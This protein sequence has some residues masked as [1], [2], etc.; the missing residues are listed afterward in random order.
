MLSLNIRSIARF[1][2]SRSAAPMLGLAACTS[3]SGCMDHTQIADL[4]ESAQIAREQ[5]ALEADRLTSLAADPSQPDAVRH[6]GATAAADLQAHLTALDTGLA[7][8]DQWLQNG[9][10]P[11]GMMQTIANKALPFLPAPMQAPA[12]LLTATGLA[13]ARAAQLKKAAGSIAQGIAKASQK[14]PE[15][16][17]VFDRHADTFR[18]VQTPA[19]KRIVDEK[20]R[21]QFM[22]RLPL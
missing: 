19:A 1:V 18:S 8:L 12:L 7:Q 11:S 20:V 22:L 15:F 21:N 10:P 14:D 4:R 2:V 17:S 5:F 13:L 6:A 16:R 9:Q 3:L